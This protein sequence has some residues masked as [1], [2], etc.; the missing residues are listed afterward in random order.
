MSTQV[1]ANRPL[2]VG[3]Y[4][5]SDSVHTLAIAYGAEQKDNSTL[6]N[7]T[8]TAL[9]GLKTLGFSAEGHWDQTTANPVDSEAFDNIGSNK[10]LTYTGGTGAEGDIAYF[11]QL[12]LSQYSPQGQ[13]GEIFAFTLEGAASD[14]LVRGTIELNA[15]V[16]S[17]G[18]ST[19]RQLGALSS[20]QK[21]VAVLHVTAAGGTTPTL[22]VVIESDDNGSFTTPT[23]R[24]TFTQATDITSELLSVNG[25]ITDDYWRA[26]YTLGGTSPEFTAVVVLG[27]IDI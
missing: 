14:D 16:S 25:A 21:M 22:D 8:R 3:S 26:E 27:I 9:G 11:A 20:T 4:D 10:V 19:G 17:T 23:D 1:I 18:T 2:W 15:A 13:V 24:I 5:F 12:L 6:S 7:S